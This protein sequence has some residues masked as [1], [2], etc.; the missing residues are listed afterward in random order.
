MLPFNPL[1]YSLL[2]LILLPAAPAE[3]LGVVCPAAV[4]PPTDGSLLPNNV[5][6]RRVLAPA[7]VLRSGGGGGG[8]TLPLLRR[9]RRQSTHHRA[10]ISS[11]AATEESNSE[12]SASDEQQ[13]PTKDE[14][15]AK[16]EETIQAI[17]ACYKVVLFTAIVDVVTNALAVR[18]VQ[19]PEH[20]LGVL[21]VLWKIGFSSGL[22]Q[23]S[24]VMQN[25]RET[26]TLTNLP[27]IVDETH[28]IMGRLWRQTAQLI[29]LGSIFELTGVFGI[30]GTRFNLP[31]IPRIFTLFAIATGIAVQGYSMKEINTAIPPTVWRRTMNKGEESTENAKNDLSV[32]EKTHTI[33]RNMALCRYVN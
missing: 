33:A 32:H 11:S 26:F 17:K 29:I 18:D 21:N 27:S 31:M 10:S 5:D 15:L 30:K 13:P 9:F 6:H 7:P 2:L 1:A 28:R 14:I 19:I 20:V 8:I 4:A 12:S 22:Y 23:I 3:S 16:Q 24:R 25:R